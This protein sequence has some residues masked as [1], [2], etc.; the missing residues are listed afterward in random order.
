MTA[1]EVD[2]T[3]VW[4]LATCRTVDCPAEAITY[5]VPCY[6]VGDPPIYNVVCMQCGQ[7]VTDLVPTT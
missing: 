3:P 5:R 2:P 1:T 4:M 7:P 6:P